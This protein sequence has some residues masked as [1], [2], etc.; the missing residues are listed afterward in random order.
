MDTLSPWSNKERVIE[1]L[2][3]GQESATQLQILFHNHKHPSEESGAS[4]AEELLQN[5]L[6]TFNHTLSALSCIEAAE[7]SQ[8]QTTC[9]DDSPWCE[10]RSRQR[11]GS[12]AKR[13]C[14]KRKRGA[15]TWTIVSATM[16]DGHSWRKYG[17]KK[18]LNSKHPRAMKQVQRMED[19]PQMYESTYIGTHTCMDSFRAPQ[20]IPD[21]ECWE[22]PQIP[23]KPSLKR[24]AKEGT[25]TGNDV[26]DLDPMV[27]KEILVADGL[28]C[29]SE[30]GMGSD[31]GAL[32][33]GFLNNKAVEFETGFHFDESGHLMV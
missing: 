32:Q 24:D 25:R 30:P 6:T 8:D 16:E 21:S 14:Y 2:M 9:N 18:I 33:Y 29:S 3:H 4:S 19:D 7:V 15:Q 13:G 27:W 22:S 5:I 10:D 23:S 31:Y 1:Q 11:L 28:D 17:Q 12:K 26:M 20:I